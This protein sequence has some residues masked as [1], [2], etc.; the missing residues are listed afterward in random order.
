MM[1]ISAF[2]KE[3]DLEQIISASYNGIFSEYMY[4]RFGISIAPEDENAENRVCLPGDVHE[5][6]EWILPYKKQIIA[7]I[8]RERDNYLRYIDQYDIGEGDGV[9][10]LW[11]NGRNQYYLSKIVGRCLTGFYFTV[12]LTQENECGKNNILVP[13]FQAAGDMRA[14]QSNIM[15]RDIFVESFL[16]APYGMIKYLDEKFDFIC[17]PDGS[18]QKFFQE[19]MIINRGICDFMR[20]YLEL[21]GEDAELSPE[22]VDRF[23][24]EYV[25]GHMELSDELK[26]V[27]YFDN[28]FVHR[29]ESKIFD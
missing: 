11:F 21:M 5:V 1:L 27:F 6:H 25:A 17:A 9:V 24:G 10:D 26:N 12:N 4:D 16:T 3:E 2:K 13:C 20:D 29:G 14:E 22:F 19:R 23:F 28:A 7:Q 18:N 15:R 8:C